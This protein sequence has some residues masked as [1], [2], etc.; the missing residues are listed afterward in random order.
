MNNKTNIKDTSNCF[1]QEFLLKYINNELSNAENSIVEN[2]I[3][4]CNICSDIV[5][6]LLMMENPNEI[7]EIAN[8]INVAIDLKTKK[9]KRVFGMNTVTFRTVAAIFLLLLGSGAFL[10]IN[11]MLTNVQIDEVKEFSQLESESFE[12]SN[13]AVFTAKEKTNQVADAVAEEKTNEIGGNKYAEYEKTRTLKK[14]FEEEEKNTNQAILKEVVL[15]ESAIV[16]G[17]TDKKTNAAY[18]ADN[19]ENINP[20]GTSS[21]KSETVSL[22]D[23]TSVKTDAAKD[24][25]L[26][27]IT[28]TRTGNAESVASNRKQEQNLNKGNRSLLK[29]KEP[30]STHDINNEQQN[31]VPQVIEEAE[32]IIEALI[33]TDNDIEAELDNNDEPIAFAVVEQKPEFHNGDSALMAYVANN[34]EYP[35]GVKE[36][37]LSG[38]IYV[39][40]TINEMG[41][42]TN[43]HVVKGLYPELD[44]E[45]V[46]VVKNMPDWVPAKQNG[47]PVAVTYILPIKIK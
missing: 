28:A 39:K 13:D 26:I 22:D 29:S 9:K 43:V 18:F 16:D 40:F 14:D 11:N 46:R 17:V 37:G 8:S 10:F 38:R 41:K 1:S 34:F 2:H 3:K 36:L 30:V 25:G 32:M 4:D 35:Q 45:A 7:I 33:I 12:E 44:T 21:V 23:D 15:S 31:D 20:T 5:D 27:N 19:N 6:G 24:S 42:V 47:K